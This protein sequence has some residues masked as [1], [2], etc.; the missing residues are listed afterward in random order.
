MFVI[1]IH[2]FVHLINYLIFQDPDEL[3]GP[4]HGARVR[5]LYQAEDQAHP[6]HEAAHR[7]AQER[8]GD[9]QVSQG[10]QF[11]CTHYLVCT[12]NETLYKHFVLHILLQFL[13]V[14]LEYLL[15]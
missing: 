9:T 15:F 14:L 8:R 3:R 7:R 6:R 12:H 2:S 4:G 10:V 13:A 11:R 1:F 5:C